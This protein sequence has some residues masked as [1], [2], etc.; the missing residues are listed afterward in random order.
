MFDFSLKFNHNFLVMKQLKT[1]Y[2]EKT[3]ARGKFSARSNLI[4]NI[5]SVIK[6]LNL[7]TI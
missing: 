7:L 5:T 4:F 3:T 6:L 2:N 1:I